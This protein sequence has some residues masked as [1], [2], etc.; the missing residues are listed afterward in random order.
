M[1]KVQNTFTRWNN[2]KK[3]WG[4][5][6]ECNHLQNTAQVEVGE[7]KERQHIWIYWNNKFSS[8]YP[9]ISANS[10]ALL[11]PPTQ[12]ESAS[13]TLPQEHSLQEDALCVSN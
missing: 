4:G 8:I 13:I 1:K 5:E 10:A 2:K 12:A 6:E 11:P 7:H 9:M 3:K